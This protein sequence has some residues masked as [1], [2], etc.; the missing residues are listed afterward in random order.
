MATGPKVV[1]DLGKHGGDPLA[2]E[3]KD[4]GLEMGPEKGWRPVVRG[5]GNLELA[6]T[7][8][9]LTCDLW[10]PSLY[11]TDT[12]PSAAHLCWCCSPPGSDIWLLL[13]KW[14]PPELSK[15]ESGGLSNF[16]S[17]D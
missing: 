15:V 11:L 8:S 5:P 7:L 16:F 4:G 10:N 17:P 13:R 2:P 1:G 14:L 3:G 12:I 9:D 6:P